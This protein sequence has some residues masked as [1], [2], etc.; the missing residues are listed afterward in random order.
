MKKINDTR[1]IASVSMLTLLLTSL[2]LAACSEEPVE[3][4]EEIL[5]PVRYTQVQAQQGGLER[6]FSGVAQ[7]GVSSRLS[8]RVSGGVDNLAVKVGDQVNKGQILAELD[9]QDLRLQLQQAR[10]AQTRAES[11][12]R[13]A[14]A[15]YARIRA[16]YEN[17]SVSRNELDT[18]RTA[19]ESARAQV[20]SAKK[21]TELAQKQLSYAVLR[22]PFPNCNVAE[23]FVETNENVSVG[24]PILELTCGD[25][26]EVEAAIPETYIS[27]I[28]EG[29]AVSVYFD[30]IPKQAFAARVT[31]VGVATRGTSTFPVTAQLIET[32]ERMRPGMA[33]ELA[34]TSNR[35]GPARIWLPTVSVLEDRKGRYV[36][37]V[38]PED[39]LVGRVERR[40]VS[41]GELSSLGIEI[42]SGLAD[43]ELVVIAGV[44]KIQ[45]QQRVK[46]L[47]NQR[48]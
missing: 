10:A 30:T 34:F 12:A 3:Q 9:S 41:I 23:T 32:D 8:F 15:S 20:D 36:F 29:Q 40:A 38:K 35:N 33:A 17:Q 37:V 27:N 22:S 19:Y 16:L 6:G 11:E 13:N 4:N 45:D 26:L 2:F 47:S 1:Q 39:E 28:S 25:T 24:Q 46:L 18:A 44:S 14:D 7:A 31:E 5:R 43:G 42:S 48:R 21:Q